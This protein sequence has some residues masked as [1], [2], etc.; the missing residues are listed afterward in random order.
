[1]DRERIPGLLER[2]GISPNRLLD[3]NF[4]TDSGLIK[5]IISLA[6]IKPGETVLEIGAGL[7]TL[8]PGI[9][10]KAGKVLAVDIDRRFEPVLKEACP[11]NVEIITGNILKL[12][13]DLRFD[14]LISNTP[15][16]ICEPL[17][18]RLAR[19]DFDRAVLT[20]PGKFIRNL[21]AGSSRLSLFTGAFFRLEVKLTIP[22]EAFFPIPKTDSGVVLL[23]HKRKP[24]YKRNPCSYILKKLF[25]Q[26]DKKLRN[27]LREALIDLHRDILNKGITN[28]MEGGRVSQT[29]DVS[30][31]KAKRDA[32][33]QRGRGPLGGRPLTKRQARD[34]MV[35]LKIRNEILDKVVRDLNGEDIKLVIRKCS[36]GN[37]NPC[38]GMRMF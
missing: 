1:M 30:A 21:E 31:S 29:R 36:P 19:I 10:G 8:T 12:I 20:L 3:Q 22:R 23:R 13:G 27:A 2:R 17:L 37:A 33:S 16:S 32:D 4:M 6:G 24:D 35:K 15:Y 9:A 5:R 26:E 18:Q 11:G 14:K 38:R 7:G 25:L 28:R 34:I